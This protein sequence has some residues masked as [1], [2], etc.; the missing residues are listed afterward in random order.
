[1]SATPETDREEPEA[2]YCKSNLKNEI[3]EDAMVYM[4]LEPEVFIAPNE[5]IRA[6]ITRAAPVAKALDNWLREGRGAQVPDLEE[7]AHEAKKPLGLAP[8]PLNEL[9]SRTSPEPESLYRWA[10]RVEAERK[11]L[12]EQDE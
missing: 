3:G 7:E 9:L 12:E 1:M 8:K 11:Q 5:P 10:D 6:T 4:P 2:P